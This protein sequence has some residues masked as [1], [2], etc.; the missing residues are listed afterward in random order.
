[1]QNMKTKRC[2]PV[3]TIVKGPPFSFIP[4]RIISRLSSLRS[5]VWDV[6]DHPKLRAFSRQ[7]FSGLTGSEVDTSYPKF[8][9]LYGPPS[10]RHL[11]VCAV[12]SKTTVDSLMAR[13]AVQL[14]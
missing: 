9:G 14:L 8:G 12:Y 6:V 10:K 3:L 1:M 11:E 5:R 2:A 4:H 7:I 13:K